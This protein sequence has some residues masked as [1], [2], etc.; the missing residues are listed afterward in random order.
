MVSTTRNL[1]ILFADISG[2]TKLYELLGNDEARAIVDRCLTIAKRACEDFGGRVVKTIGDEVMAAFPT[3]DSAA[4]AAIEIQTGVSKQRTSRGTPVAMH[5]GFHS[6]QAIEDEN[7]VF[8]DC[9]NVA[10]RMTAFASAGQIFTSA[11]TTAEL[12]PVLRQRTR[13]QDAQTLKGKERDIGLFEVIWGDAE[14]ELTAMSPR[15]ARTPPK[16][17]LTHA[18]RAIELSEERS[19]LTLGRDARNDVVIA[20]RKASRMHARIE[21]RRDKFVF[22][23]QSSNGTWVTVEGEPEITL[24]REELILR[25]RGQISFGHAFADDP[26]E[27]VVFTCQG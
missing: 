10:A 5:I 4:Q 15:L 27:I 6:G 25:G 16:V 13:D 14:D 12:S 17:T 24:R 26:T 3:A 20:D 23:D 22:I 18:A 1:A 19:L 11:H 2:S 9:V 7:D 21:R 8:G